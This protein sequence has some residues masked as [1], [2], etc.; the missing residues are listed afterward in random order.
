MAGNV[1][2]K[3]T[4]A[5]VSLVGFPGTYQSMHQ[6][7][8][9]KG[10]DP[11]NSLP[12]AGSPGLYEIT[13]ILNRP[14]YKLQPEGQ[15]TFSSGLPGDSH[16]AITKP[17]YTPP[18][19]PDATEIRILG[20]TPDGT[21]EFIG[22]PNAK[23]FLGKLVSLPFMAKN[24]NHAEEIAYRAIA[25]PLSNVSIH[26]D[27]PIEIG[28]RETKELATQSIQMSFVSPNLEAPFAVNATVTPSQDFQSYAALYREALNTNSPVYQYLCLFKIIESLRKRRIRL[29]RDAKKAG[30]VYIPPSEVLPSTTTEIRSWLEGLFYI[31]RDFD[32]STFESAVPPGLRARSVSDVFETVLNPIRKNVAHALFSGGGELPLESDDLLHTHKVTQHLLVTKCIVRRMLKNDFPNEFLNHLAG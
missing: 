1:P 20:Q 11:R 8:R 6:I 14:G 26:L 31:R 19:N 3:A 13:F 10:D 28:H 12:L 2:L 15:L 32:L 5:R 4:E 16:L 23:G 29:E 27:I 21:F 9:Y 7:Y 22:L 17:A 25:S 24:R 18:G 30:S